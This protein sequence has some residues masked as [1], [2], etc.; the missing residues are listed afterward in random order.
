MHSKNPTLG[1]FSPFW[2]QKHY[3]Q[4]IQLC[5]AQHHMGPSYHV[6]FQ[7]KKLKSQFQENRRTGR[8]TGRPYSQDPSGHGHGSNK[9]IRELR[10]IAVDNK[11]KIQCNSAYH[12]SLT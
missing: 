6:E 3:F 10:V 4:K 2:R 5:H 8:R 12:T 11:N 7:K 1:L 9:R